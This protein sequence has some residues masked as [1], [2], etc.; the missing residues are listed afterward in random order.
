MPVQ[1]LPNHG[2]GNAAGA[3]YHGN[4]TITASDVSPDYSR[5]YKPEAQAKDGKRLTFACG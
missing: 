1:I 5:Q 3:K 4:N 2:D